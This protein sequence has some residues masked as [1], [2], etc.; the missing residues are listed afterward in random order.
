MNKRQARL[1][2]I[3]KIL[4]N[5]SIGSQEE[6]MELLERN[7]CV[8]TQAT[9]SRDLKSLRTSKVSTEM[10]GYRYVIAANGTAA[11]E[12]ATHAMDTVRQAAILSVAVSGSMIIIK[13]RNGYA[14]GVAYDIDEISSP[15]ILGTIAGADTVF[16][17]ISSDAQL[18]EI[19][20][21]FSNIL[22]TSVLEAGK[23]HFFANN[24]INT[25]LK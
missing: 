7:N 25:S 13:T 22:P 12:V 21:L 4:L 24:T 18:P 19:Y 14:G 6:L 16:V 17:A 2:L 23:H 20:T 1:A 5:N 3:V 10:G 11:D 8:V 9:L 15:Y